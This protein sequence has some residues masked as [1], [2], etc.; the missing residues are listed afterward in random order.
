[1]PGLAAAAGAMSFFKVACLAGVAT[2]RGT[3]ASSIAA[4]AALQASSP[5]PLLRVGKVVE[6]LRSGDGAFRWVVRRSPA[7]RRRARLTHSDRFARAPA[8][9]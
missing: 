3:A 6:P 4:Q 2:G 8:H 9:C 5:S 1:M 7:H